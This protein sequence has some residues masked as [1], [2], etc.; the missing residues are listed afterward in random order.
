MSVWS[1]N[2]ALDARL[3]ELAQEGYSTSQIARALG[4]GIS[5]CA[6]IGRMSRQ[7]IATRTIK[8]KDQ[9]PRHKPKPFIFPHSMPSQIKF[10][11]APLKLAPDL[12]APAPLVDEEGKPITGD[13][14]FDVTGTNAMVSHEGR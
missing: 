11:A 7:N 1:D 2:P 12:E 14:T 9:R 6:V 10:R 13:Y 4:Y 8:P 3:A 5:R